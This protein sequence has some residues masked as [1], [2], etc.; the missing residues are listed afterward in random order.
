MRTTI[1]RKVSKDALERWFER[2]FSSELAALRG[3]RPWLA[4]E[5]AGAVDSALTRIFDDQG[6]W[7]R[8]ERQSRRAVID[9][10]GDLARVL[11]TD[12]VVTNA[13]T[14]LELKRG[15]FSR[16]IDPDSFVFKSV[17]VDEIDA[18]PIRVILKEAAL[19]KSPLFRFWETALSEDLAGELYE[20]DV[21]SRVVDL[22]FSLAQRHA[23]RC[24]TTF[25]R[26][27]AKGVKQSQKRIDCLLGPARDLVSQLRRDAA[28]LQ[29]YEP[30]LQRATP[31]I[32]KLK[33]AG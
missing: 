25:G 14:L 32:A 26:S 11:R 24:A 16:A 28:A 12:K 2:T 1:T 27:S 30:T 18:G 5:L 3:W 17:A 15:T 13:E 29:K 6:S 7:M 19:F 9:A 33:R 10:L 22:L 4:E 21:V 20:I 8:K 23:K 31:V